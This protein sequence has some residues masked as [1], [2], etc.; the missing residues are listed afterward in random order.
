M[1]APAFLRHL[2]IPA[3]AGGALLIGLGVAPMLPGNLLQ[4]KEIV[5]APPGGA[6]MSFAQLIEKVSPAVVYIEV[7]KKPDP[8]IPLNQQG[9]DPDRLPPG[10]DLRQIPPG[11]IPDFYSVGSGFFISESGTVVTN[12][13][14]VDRAT[15]IK[16]KTG[17][18]KEYDAEL[19][20]A[21]PLTD[22]AVL[23]LKT[24]DK[25]FPFVTFDR[26]ADL[27]V[28]DWVIAVGSPFGLQ[29]TAT[30]GIVSAKGRRELG[31]SSYVD[32]IQT[33]ASINQG[34]SG[35]PTFDL[36][37]RVVGVNT[38]IFSPTGGSVGIGFAIPSETA[39]D[40]VDSLLA[41]GKVTRGWIG[42]TVQPLDDELAR[43]L[44]LP[45]AKGAMVAAVVPEG[46]AAR[47]GVQRGDV[48]LKVEGHAI[49]D[50]RDLTRRVGA[51]AVG[52]N[53]KVEVLRG[54]ARRTLQ[55]TFGERPGEQQ[56]SAMVRSGNVAPFQPAPA[57]APTVTA[58]GIDVRPASALERERVGVEERLAGG[59]VITRVGVNSS[60]A[61]KGLRAG[62]VI[63]QADGKTMSRGEDL[64]GAI[65]AAT[66]AKRPLNLLIQ[67]PGGTRFVGAEVE[68]G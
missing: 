65:E 52:K 8:R 25:A 47:G 16:V 46:P 26:D 61:R 50:S 58:L 56:L 22:L 21:D 15:E 66:R 67:T 41:N 45:D 48:I 30:A 5:V 40:V 9:I 35:G 44:G 38:S 23:K 64:T 39:A 32:F 57:E 19:V 62:D 7:R 31:G 29:G 37:G 3:V 53:A 34:N 63:L 13:H 55:V 17:A 68:A 27:R 1:S 4:A 14:V 49:E 33:D 43:S 2:L 54:G 59:L 12:N 20:G 36:K 10:F 28:G 60:L 18:G 24:T 6:P 51:Y 42:V 11:E